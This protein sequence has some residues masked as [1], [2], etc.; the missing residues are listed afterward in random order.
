MGSFTN[1]VQGSH[2]AFMV[3]VVKVTLARA[4]LSI[5]W[6]TVLTDSITSTNI[7]SPAHAASLPVKFDSCRPTG[8]PPPFFHSLVFFCAE[9]QL[10]LLMVRIVC[11]VMLAELCHAVY[12]GDTISVNVARRN[13]GLTFT[14]RKLA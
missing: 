9:S 6:D 2:F 13:V 7:I 14:A 5:V 11:A 12:E 10:R 3:P 1:V 4:E 8:L